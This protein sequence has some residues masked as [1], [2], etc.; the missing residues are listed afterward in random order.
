MF[1]KKDKQLNLYPHEFRIHIYNLHQLYLNNYRSKKGFIG[2]SVVIDYVNKLHVSQQMYV[3][4]N[5]FKT[6]EIGC[7][8][9]LLPL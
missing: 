5:K 1:H 9:K 2:F 7:I 8:K 3:L 6:R 4:N